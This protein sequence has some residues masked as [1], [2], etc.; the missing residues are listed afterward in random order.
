MALSPLRPPAALTAAWDRTPHRC[1]SV[2]IIDSKVVVT[3]RAALRSRRT[4]VKV[5]ADPTQRPWVWRAHSGPPTVARLLAQLVARVVPDPASVLGPTLTEAAHRAQDP[6]WQNLD[7]LAQKRTVAPTP[8]D[9]IAP[10]SWPARALAA[11]DAIRTGT[12]HDWALHRH[13]LA[14]HART[15]TRVM[16]ALCFAA[17]D[18]DSLAI[19]GS[20]APTD[21]TPSG[22]WQWLTQPSTVPSAPPVS[23]PLDDRIALAARAIWWFTHPTTADQPLQDSQPHVHTAI[24]STVDHH[25]EHF[26][27]HGWTVLRNAVRPEQ[28]AAWRAHLSRDFQDTLRQ[29]DLAGGRLEQARRLRHARHLKHADKLQLDDPHTPFEGKL[30]WQ[31]GAKRPLHLLAPELAATVASLTHPAPVGFRVHDQLLITR[32]LQPIE[33]A[34]P[35]W[36]IDEVQEAATLQ[37]LRH[38]ALLLVL[39]TDVT[40][41]D[42][43]TAFLP[44]SPPRV[45]QALAQASAPLN[46]DNRR[47]TAALAQDCGPP[48]LATGQAGDVYLLHPLTLHARSASYSRRLRVIAN[49]NLWSAE[50]VDYV[51]PRS[52]VE[53]RGGLGAR[54]SDGR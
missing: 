36:H 19:L 37:S 21:A 53:K 20:H 5:A 29:A 43:P 11:L 15:D 46:T 6:V 22:L 24:Q 52:T 28:L 48:R 12:P 49:I 13:A 18:T 41:K 47:W 16:A 44:D 34:T 8:V 23:V 9:A 10:M 3:I 42:G 54:L 27:A 38:V 32:H 40:Q 2:E 35:D 1:L 45:V 14:A 17:Q 31:T 26:T 30:R 33:P 7:Q 4:T 50:P 39:L 51:H 25:V